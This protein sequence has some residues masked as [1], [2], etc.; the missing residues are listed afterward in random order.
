[1]T[2]RRDPRIGMVL[3]DRYRIDAKIARGGMAMVYRGTDLR[4]DREIAIKVMHEHLISDDTF[5]ERF[6]REAINAGRL[7]HPNLVA[8]H[9]QARDGDIVY[10]V[11]EH[12]P[13]VTLRR[14]LK[15]RSTFT[16]RQ[17]IVVLDAI[18]AALEAVHSTGIIHRDL[19]PDNVL[20]GTD[21][22][23]K[24]ADFG[25]ARAVTTATTTKTLIGTVGYVAPELVTRAGADARTDLYTVGIMFYEMLTGAQ[26]YTDDVPIQVAYR[27]V[28]D[29]VPPP[30][31]VVAHLSPRLD[32]LV[33]WATS[34]DPEDRPADAAEFR[35]ALAE[36]RAEMSDA[37]LD[38]GDPQIAAGEHSPVLTA[39]IDL[40][41]VAPKEKRSRTDEIPYLEGEEDDA[42]G[43]PDAAD[44]ADGDD[45]SAEA[46]TTDGSDDADS[47]DDSDESAG[48]AIAA[49]GVG[50]AGAAAAASAGA[51]G[52]SADAQA[53]DDAAS[54]DHADADET[55]DSSAE[56]DSDGEQE[57]KDSD[58][59]RD[60]DD[61]R[62]GKDKA[63]VVAGSA[64]ASA[65]APP[66][67]RRR[68]RVLVGLVAVVAV[69]ALVAWFVVANLPA[70]TSIVPGELAGKSVEEV[71]T[72]LEDNDLK[73]EPK[74]V[75]DDKVPAGT[76]I[77]T[78]PVSGAELAPDS[79]VTVVVSKGEEKFA[80]PKLEGLSRDEAEGAL[81]KV[82][83]EVGKVDEEYSDTVAE[84]TV[85]SASQKPGTKLSKGEKIDLVLSKG[86]APIPVP[87]V[88]GLTFDA[89]YAT[90]A[91]RGFRVGKDEVFSDDVPKGKVVS[92]FP[93]S[94]E[95]KPA[96]S[97]I[98]V[99]VSKGKEKRE[100][101][102]SK[103]DKKDEKKDDS[104]DKKSDDKKDEDK[105][106]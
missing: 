58:S 6:R 84:D 26:P 37:E 85:I 5:V 27:H 100:E 30:S 8:I 82:N 87:N 64:A 21:G 48:G 60:D 44:D 83:L 55:D 13:S 74:K 15:H 9:D 41:E 4:L 24:L 68:R 42:A 63:A 29:T 76:V 28:H 95:A 40:G 12:L 78:E 79:S 23:V 32:A 11:M 51:E 59:D 80:V 90:L 86:V 54:D 35:L 53:S 50:A 2:A 45:S 46:A 38:L 105:D 75:F 16:P 77:G 70:P 73:A 25:L 69:L 31:D 18:L 72:Q 49:A 19:K 65:G 52:N 34:K 56:E 104:K 71:T 62:D 61:D 22:Q 97:L 1:M 43:A 91:K 17:A 57:S 94:T 98:I 93:K 10:L 106:K 101:S 103:D 14:E 39:S 67:R 66:A 36:A 88:E 96:N 33:L 7:T 81:K 47:D 102:D 92:Q 89:A 20:L 3:N 99:R